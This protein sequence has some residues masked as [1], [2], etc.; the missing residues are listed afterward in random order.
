MIDEQRDL[1]DIKDE[2]IEELYM[3][4]VEERSVDSGHEVL[5][6]LADTFESDVGERGEDGA[7]QWRWMSDSSVKV[8]SRGFEN[9][10]KVHEP[11]H[12]GYASHHRLR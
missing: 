12:G 4:I 10:G 5:Q 1:V 9:D 3:D 2:L 7:C 6:V 11:F 8:R